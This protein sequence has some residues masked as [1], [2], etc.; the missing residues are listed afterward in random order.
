MKIRSVKQE[1]RQAARMAKRCAV[2]ER[3]WIGRGP[4]YLVEP[5]VARA[6][7]PSL[8][9]I[10]VALRDDTREIDDTRV[11]SVQEFPHLLR[12]TIP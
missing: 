1:R 4:R 3:P 8:R 6:C 10:A 9:S 5:T 12:F 11:A 7:A 2:P